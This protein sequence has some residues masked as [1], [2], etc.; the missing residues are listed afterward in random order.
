MK[1]KLMIALISVVVFV[2]AI[3]AWR[4]AYSLRKSNDNLPTLTMVAEMSE[5]EVNS[6]LPGYKI[7]QLT[8]VWG[9]PDYSEE[10]EARW[11]IG[12]MILIVN[13][14]NN[15]VV[16]ICGLKEEIKP[17]YK[18][19]ITGDCQLENSLKDTYEAGEQVTIKLATITEH[20]YVV[21]ANGVEQPMDIDASDLTYTYYTFTMPA[22][23]VLVEIEGV[24]VDIPEVVEPLVSIAEFS[25]AEEREMYS[26]ISPSIK[27]SGFVNTSTV[28]INHGNVET[29]AKNEC[30]IEFDSVRTYLDTAECM[31]KVEFY[32]EGDPFES[33][34]VYLD[35][36]G[37][38]VLSVYGYD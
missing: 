10:N 7:V 24:S 16:A 35:Y 26:Y 1:R 28:E 5:T 23:D 2:G 13:Y 15:G 25:F 17:T 38:T 20:Y 22:E 4:V 29:H 21:Y 3:F 18:V 14:K 11:K 8:E 27:T 12:N 34:T 32:N 9:E 37:K 6:L 31:W 19:D 30:N 33:Q 36:D